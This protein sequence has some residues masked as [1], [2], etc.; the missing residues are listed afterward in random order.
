MRVRPFTVIFSFILL[1]FS[2]FTAAESFGQS[3]MTPTSTSTSEITGMYTDP[4]GEIQMTLP[5]DWKS[6][7][8]VSDAGTIVISAPH[9]FSIDTLNEV[10][11]AMYLIIYEKAMVDRAPDTIPPYSIGDVNCVVQLDGSTIMSNVVAKLS[12]YRCEASGKD[13]VVRSVLA[14]THD[15]WVSLMLVTDVSKS[16]TYISIFDKALRTMLVSDAIDMDVNLDV[17][18]TLKTLNA[19]GTLVFLAIRSSSNLTDFAFDEERMVVSFTVQGHV[20]TQGV[21]DVSIGKIFEGPYSVLIDDNVTNNFEVI[22]GATREGNRVIVTYEHDYMTRISISGT[23]VVP[24]FPAHLLT[25]SVLALVSVVVI[26]GKNGF[27]RY[28]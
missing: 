16:D 15:R 11:A 1:I 24:E 20:G 21:T 8:S 4:V 27:R 28:S 5:T 7:E 2:S 19:N 9:D 6:I 12:T 17:I 10:D 13:I 22:E 3:S 23:K 14:Q 25:V 26:L 18:H